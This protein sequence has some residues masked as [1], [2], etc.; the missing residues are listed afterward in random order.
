VVV[1][2]GGLVLE[3]NEGFAEMC[4]YEHHEVFG[5]TP[6]DVTTPEGAR[7]VVENIR[8][9]LHAPYVVDG[10][11]KSGELFP[12]QIQ[13]SECYYRGERVRITGFRDLTDE[14]REE[15]RRR[16]LQ[17]RVETAQRLEGLGILAGGIA[18][19]FNNLLVGVLGNADLL[20]HEL[21][22]DGPARARVRAIR[23]ASSRAAELVKRMLAYAGRNQ[24]E[25]RSVALAEV[26]EDTI[27]LLGP[28]LRDRSPVQL[29]FA[30]DVPGAEGDSGQLRQ[31]IMN[32]VANAVEATPDPAAP[33]TV[34]VRQT[35]TPL[36]DDADLVPAAPP[37]W[38]ELSVEDRGTG[39]D[40]ETR[41][42][43]FDPFFSTRFAGRGL[44]LAATLGI[45]RSHRGGLSVDSEPGRGTTVRVLLPVSS[46]PP[47][48]LEDSLPVPVPAP[49]RGRVLVVDDEEPVREVLRAALSR[50]GMEVVLAEHAEEGLRLAIA[51][52]GAFDLFVLDLTM[53]GMSGEELYEELEQRWPAQPIL[54]TSGHDADGMVAELVHGGRAGFLP[55]PFRVAALLSKV[56]EVLALGDRA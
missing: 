18:H 44:G 20:E 28:T 10:V 39:M 21:P 33:V 8:S 1:S 51:Q 40:A 38:V 34:S 30:R 56:R 47:P 42:R 32:L 19:D 9:E 25:I 26:V 14:R 24:L 17:L 7:T 55:K 15:E 45:V 5:M 16:R 11:R 6:G 53:P 2:R 22:A 54:F 35:A 46:E 29:R 52:D 3:A 37:P 41:A 43:M 48:E 12:M 4:G 23:R 50:T 36:P 13:G 31:V 27:E 49:Q